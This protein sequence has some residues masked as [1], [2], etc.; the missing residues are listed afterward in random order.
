MDVKLVVM[1]G[2]KERKQ[3]L[4]VRH[5]ETVIGRQSGCQLRIPSETV[6]R[7]HCRLR[8]RDDCV[9]VED[10]G[11]ANGTR[12]NGVPV[13]GIQVVKPGDR[14]EVGPIMFRVEYAPQQPPP[15]FAPPSNEE[16]IPVNFQGLLEGLLD[17]PSEPP[18][19]AK[20]PAE[21]D[22]LPLVDD[23]AAALLGEKKVE[24]KPVLDD[25]EWRMPDADDLR[26][27]LSGLDDS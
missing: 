20:A 14:L 6:S 15:S 21:L 13:I 4:R 5:P 8:V 1:R 10:L 12:L 16:A 22:A 27:I 2:G 24:E 11:S 19:V 7:R 17:A 26:D 23:V 18:T 3:A 25:D 9:T